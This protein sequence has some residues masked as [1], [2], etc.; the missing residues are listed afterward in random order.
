MQWSHILILALLASLVWVMNFLYTGRKRR[1]FYKTVPCPPHSTFWGHLKLIGETIRELPPR[2]HYQQMMVY[3]GQKYNMP[4]VFYLDL[5]PVSY[6]IMIIQDPGVAVQITQIKSL[7]KHMVNR[8]YTQPLTGRSSVVLV[9]GAEWKLIRSI[10]NP[11]F[12]PQYIAS[13][14]PILSKHITRF[15]D[16]LSKAA[17]SGETFLL[18]G[19]ILSLTFDVISEVVLGEDLDSQRAYSLLAYHYAQAA[20]FSNVSSTSVMSFSKL[21]SQLLKRWYSRQEGLIIADMIKKRWVEQKDKATGASR[22]GIDLFLQAYQ[23]EKKL[24]RSD[25]PAYQDTYFMEIAVDNVKSL[26]LG[27]HDTTSSTLSW[28]LALLAQNPATLA[29][30]RKEHD[31]VFGSDISHTTSLLSLDAALLSSLPYTTAAIKEAMRIFPA[32]STTRFSNP[33]D[34]SHP[35]HV[36]LTFDGKEVS[37]PVQDQQ[38]WVLHYGIG[39]RADLWPDP[40]AFIPERHLPNPPY[41]YPKDAWRSFEKGPRACAGMEL[42]MN[43]MKMVIVEVSRRFDFEVAYKEDDPDAPEGHGG[44]MYQV[45][46]FAAKPAGH[47]PMRVKE[48]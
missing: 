19:Y 29:K 36:T 12:A 39:Q 35:T 47:M 46:E 37:L 40:H 48:R 17:K 44:K 33:K 9:E 32:A 11:G 26:L 4:P 6:G 23:D 41:P 7:P 14:T 25:K 15:T 2:F 3:I 30:V 16:K 24:P 18:Q 42:A 1:A 21:R 5:W 43:E 27:G 45:M 20:R 10:M 13:L 8:A 31:E 28:V 22:A 38:A 34:P